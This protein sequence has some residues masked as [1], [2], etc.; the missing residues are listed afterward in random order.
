MG[1]EGD[2]VSDGAHTLTSRAVLTAEPSWGRMEQV[3]DG[4]TDTC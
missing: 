3:G 2:H 1:A 4:R